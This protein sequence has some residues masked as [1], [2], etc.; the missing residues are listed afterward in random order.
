MKTIVV[1][2]LAVLILAVAI[3]AAGGASRQ[4]GAHPA[5]AII[6]NGTVQLGIWDEGH[7]NVPGGTPSS[8][9]GTTDVG[10]R[11]VPSN[12]EATAPGC[13]CEGWGAADATSAA[14]G[15]ANEDFGAP[16]NLTVE[17]FTF[18]ADS[19]TSVV[20]VGSTLRVTHD[21]QPS[22]LTPNLYQVTVT[23][24]NISGADVDLRYRRV[25]D[26]DVEPTA[27][28]EFVTI[29]PG[30]ATE[31][32][33][34][35]NDG[36]ASPDPLNGPSDLG[37]TGAFTDVG[38]DDHGALFDFGFGTVAPGATKQ[39]RTY[40]GAAANETEALAALA[41]VG[42][43]VFSLGQPDT[44][45]GPTLGTPN[46]FIFA[47]SGVGGAPVFAT[48]TPTPTP[49]ATATPSPTP[50]PSPAATALPPTGGRPTGGSGSVPWLAVAI[51]A[52]ALMSGGAWLAYQRRHAR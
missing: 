43:E 23:I 10:V 14:T 42:A 28:S 37:S 15:W 35:S 25:M 18:D 41:A 32:L 51:G 29:D 24:E 49:T 48:P 27:F 12:T 2:P 47:F 38:P 31:L 6:D 26:W 21:Y 13:L 20:T 3:F 46:T 1:I 44:A 45:D 19:A 30:T 16:F 22:P 17:S 11:Y 50:V 36:F 8:G 33:F 7:L 5:S 39:F 40:Y 34:D 9:E 4:A 52:L